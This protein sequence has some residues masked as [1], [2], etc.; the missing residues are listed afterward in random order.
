VKF[1]LR[2]LVTDRLAPDQLSFAEQG[3]TL[4]AGFSGLQTHVSA[5]G[6][7]LEAVAERDL[8]AAAAMLQIAFPA[9]HIGAVEI[10]YLNQGTLE[11]YVRVRVTISEE[12]HLEIVAQL[13]QRRAVIESL[14]D[15]AEKQKI[16]SAIA[17]LADMLGYDE[18]AAASTGN[19]AFV[20]YAFVDYR[21]RHQY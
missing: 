17:S 21:P 8:A 20:D 3:A 6:L 15:V 4:L 9:V 14:E 5:R 16:I 12:C 10:V 18:V 1:P 7:I 11:P 2:Q 13:V 19:R